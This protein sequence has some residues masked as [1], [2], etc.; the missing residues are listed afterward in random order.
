M[1]TD[2]E[3]EKRTS[4]WTLFS[5]GEYLRRCVQQVVSGVSVTNRANSKTIYGHGC[6]AGEETAAGH[7][8]AEE[9][10]LGEIATGADGKIAGRAAA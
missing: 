7:R 9:S 1:N 4:S 3:Q 8:S 10:I 5:R 6:G 2:V